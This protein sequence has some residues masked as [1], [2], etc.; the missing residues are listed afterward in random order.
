MGRKL[1]ILEEPVRLDPVDRVNGH[2]ASEIVPRTDEA[3][4]SEPVVKPEPRL[5]KSPFQIDHR[6]EFIAELREDAGV[7]RE[8]ARLDLEEAEMLERA[9]RHMEEHPPEE[10]A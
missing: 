6:G 3:R 9:A 7:L 4:Q 2:A 10:E 8:R 5:I 1:K